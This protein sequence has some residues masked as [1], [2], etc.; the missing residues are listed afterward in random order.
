MTATTASDVS[1]VEYY[2]ACTS[3]GG[4]DSGW[5]DDTT[6]VDTGL[7]N[8]TTYA[9]KVMV[10]DKS[11]AKNETLWSNE[12]SAT[13]LRYDCPGGLI[14]DLNND[15]Q[16]DFMDYALLASQWSAV[17]PIDQL[18]SLSTFDDAI[19]ASWQAITLPGATGYFIGYFDGATGNPPGSAVVGSDADPAGTDG[20]WFYQIIP[21]IAGKQYKLSGEWMGDLTGYVAADPCN[22]GNWANVMVSF[23]SNPDPNTWTSWSSPSAL[24]YRKAF[25]STTQNIGPWGAWD[26]EQLTASPA[27][28]PADGIFTATGSHMIV[29]FSTGGLPASGVGY[30]YLDNVRVQTSPCPTA[31]FNGDCFLDMKDLAAFTE[32][33]LTCN[34]N[35]AGECWQ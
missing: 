6:Y 22:R 16:V 35:P 29:A 9:Y 4:H 23:E 32:Q 19:P 18:V 21:A 26:W 27:N 33:W 24:M 17:L 1:G 14:P 25:G 8:N 28:G 10:R 7:V 12:A 5:Q 3:G 30:Y 2:F 15:C 34:R 13:T 20:Q 11:L 31:D